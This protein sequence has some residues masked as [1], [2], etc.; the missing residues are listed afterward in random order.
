MAELVINDSSDVEE[1]TNLLSEAGLTA[2]KKEDSDNVLIIDDE[3]VAQV[4]AVLD[5][6]DIDYDWTG[7]AA[8]AEGEE[9]EDEDEDE[10]ENEEE[11]EDED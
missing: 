9:D 11:N 2:T 1:A 10:D 8:A 4:E 6:S 7:K 3:S 5:A